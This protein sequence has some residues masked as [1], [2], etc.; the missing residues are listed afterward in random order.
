MRMSIS[1]KNKNKI[2][3][4][5]AGLMGS[6]IVRKL[7]KVGKIDVG[8]IDNNKLRLNLCKGAKK[9]YCDCLDEK[10]LKKIIQGYNLC[11]IALSSRKAS[12]AVMKACVDLKINIVDIIEEYHL[13]PE[14]E[15]PANAEYRERRRLQKVGELIHRS[16]LKNHVTIIDGMGFAPGL[17]NITVQAGLDKL[18]V[19]NDV[20]VRVGGIPE[21]KFKNSYPF[22]YSIS[23]SLRHVLREYVVKTKI[24]RNG[25]LLT[26]DAM[27]DLENFVF[28]AF[29][30]KV[31]FECFITGGMPSFVFTRKRQV[32]NFCEKTI[33]WPGHCQDIQFLKAI[34]MF[35]EKNIQRLEEFLSVAW[36]PKDKDYGLCVM[37]NS[38]KGK[39]NGRKASVNYYLYGHGDKEYSAMARA[40][41]FPAVIVAKFLLQNL[42]SKVGIIAPEE[43]IVGKLYK[44]FLSELEQEG[45]IIKEKVQYEN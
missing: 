25:K 37:W 39:K 27:S 36:R 1:K 38:V 2:I 19:V 9:Y 12:Y 23:W 5:G 29:Q 40:T 44:L 3:V 22:H 10:N 35:K 6:A 28:D 32:K 30:H 26:V 20:V 21:E 43:V 41:V 4:A 14:V 42:V 45:I 15:Y 31:K 7:L 33:R 17:S 8:V 18:D 11:I 24:L 34:G 13:H 16:A